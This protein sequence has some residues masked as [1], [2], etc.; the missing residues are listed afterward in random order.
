MNISDLYVATD[1]QTI[2][3]VVLPRLSQMK[4]EDG[5]HLTT[6]SISMHRSGSVIG[7]SWDIAGVPT[8]ELVN[9]VLL[10]LAVLT[11]SAAQLTTCC[12][13]SQPSSRRFIRHTN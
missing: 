2:I 13:P 5:L 10:E 11:Q 8:V 7:G 1:N 3:D 6:F 9:N 4:R 12:P